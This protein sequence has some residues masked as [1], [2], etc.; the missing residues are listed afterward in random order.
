MIKEAVCRYYAKTITFEVTISLKFQHSTSNSRPDM[1]R[2]PNMNVVFD[3]TGV[4][5]V[6]PEAGGFFNFEALKFTLK[7]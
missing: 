4:W 6:T 3:L 5:G 2:E 7:Y 1:Q